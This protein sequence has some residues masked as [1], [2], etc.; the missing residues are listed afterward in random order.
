MGVF[1][2]VS[3]ISNI[4]WVLEIPDIFLW[5]AVDAGLEPTYEKKWE[6]P[7]PPLGSQV[8]IFKNIIF[9]SLKNDFVLA[10]V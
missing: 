6:Y 4:F 9:L 7:P 10:K 5:W 1:F 2:G 8:I 3:E